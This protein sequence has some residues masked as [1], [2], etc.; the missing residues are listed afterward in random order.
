[1]PILYRPAHAEEL[2]ATQQHIVR[3]INDLSERHGF[4][5]MA[6]VRAPDFQLFSLKDDPAG[7]WTAEENGGIVRSQKFLIDGERFLHLLFG[8]L[9]ISAA[10]THHTNP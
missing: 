2:P 10:L 6:S 3:S 9:P 5:P 8:A 1:M 4:G 7:L